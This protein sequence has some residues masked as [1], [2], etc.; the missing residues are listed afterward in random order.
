MN[1]KLRIIFSRYAEDDLDEI[2]MYYSSINAGYAKKLFYAIEEKVNNLKDF[3]ESGRIVPELE[4]QNIVKFRELIE[5]NYRIVYEFGQQTV[6]IHAI[7]DSRRNLEELII[8]KI[9]KFY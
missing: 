5:G 9:S 7:V 3:S 8:K 2:L 4:E 6:T 1:S